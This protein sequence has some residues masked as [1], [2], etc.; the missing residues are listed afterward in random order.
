MVGWPMSRIAGTKSINAAGGGG[1]WAGVR[2]GVVRV[3]FKCQDLKIL[4]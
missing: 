1:G 2:V 3:R 4:S